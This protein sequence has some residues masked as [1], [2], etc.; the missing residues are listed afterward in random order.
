MRPPSASALRVGSSEFVLWFDLG[1]WLGNRQ[2]HAEASFALDHA[3][4]SVGRLF[5]RN[6]LDH[7][8]N[9]LEDTKLKRVLIVDRLAGQ[10]AVNRS[11]TEDQRQ[12]A[13]WYRIWGHS[14]HDELTTNGEPCYQRSHSAAT[15]SRRKDRIGS[16][17]C[18]QSS[19]SVFDP[20]VD[21]GV[22][23]KI[24]RKFF[25]VPS[26]R[27]RHG[28]ESHAPRELDAE[29]AKTTHALYRDKITRAEPG[30]A[31]RIVC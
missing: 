18:L 4:V 7:R 11:A 27:Q 13:D 5:E 23:A 29:M 6:R 2:N 31:K 16:S 21:I 9:I 15:G 24:L 17:H 28:P 30:I 14:N 26:S 8:T 25:L 1:G 12:R 19:S 10:T 22:C 3:C 20:S